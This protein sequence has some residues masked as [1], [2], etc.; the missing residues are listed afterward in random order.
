MEA[1]SEVERVIRDLLVFFATTSMATGRYGRF[2]G[3][4]PS[5]GIGGPSFATLAAVRPRNPPM[6]FVKANDLVIHYLDQGRRDGP[7]LVRS[8]PSWRDWWPST[9]GGPPLEGL[10]APGKAPPQQV[11]ES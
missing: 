2:R 9:P 10:G 5:S 3:R 8:H 6:R 7:P 1:L 4:S 11:A